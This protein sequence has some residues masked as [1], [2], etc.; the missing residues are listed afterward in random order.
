MS[1]NLLL[2]PNFEEKIVLWA[3]GA[4]TICNAADNGK[5]SLLYSTIWRTID[6]LMSTI[7]LSKWSSVIK[8]SQ[9]QDKSIFVSEKFLVDKLQYFGVNYFCIHVMLSFKFR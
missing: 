7:L 4:Y 8:C 5:Y 2:S 9:L 6:F 1:L 3:Q